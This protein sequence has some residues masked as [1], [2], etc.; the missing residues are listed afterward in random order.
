M[1]CAST[2]I[3]EFYLHFAKD[4]SL[5]QALSHIH[6]ESGSVWVLGFYLRSRGKTTVCRQNSGNC[7]KSKR[8]SILQNVQLPEAQILPLTNTQ[9]GVSSQ[10]QH[11]YL[12]SLAIGAF[13]HLPVLLGDI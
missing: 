12:L 10:F 7:L 4:K 9:V 8:Q 6:C 3:V 2:I 1:S 11:Q 5:W 13:F